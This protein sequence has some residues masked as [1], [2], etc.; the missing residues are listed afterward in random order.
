MEKAWVESILKD[1][2]RTRIVMAIENEAG[3]VSGFVQL[4]DID[5]IDRTAELAVGIG[6]PNE[7][8]QGIGTFATRLFIREAFRT[9]GLRR[10]FVRIAAFN[11]SGLHF[12]PKFGFQH[13]GTLRQHVIRDGICHDV[14][15]FGLLESEVASNFD[16]VRKND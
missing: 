7:R 1:Q 2:T 5:W 13:E 9:Y 16:P 6:E 14:M 10:L 15:I 3:G 12:F 8:G 11:E 4:N